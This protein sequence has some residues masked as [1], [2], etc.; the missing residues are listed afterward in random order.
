MSQNATPVTGI[1]MVIQPSDLN[2]KLS[3]MDHQGGFL[4]RYYNQPI[5]REENAVLCRRMQNNNKMN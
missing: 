4:S 5:I 1:V 3:Q 2:N